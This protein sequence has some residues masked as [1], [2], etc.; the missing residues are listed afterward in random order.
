M[1]NH[2]KYK[3]MKEIFQ[4]I[5]IKEGY[6]LIKEGNVYSKVFIYE[7]KPLILV[8]HSSSQKESIILSYKEFLRQVNFDFQVYMMNRKYNFKEYTKN[9]LSHL[10]QMDP[11]YQNYVFD[12]QEKIRKEL[13]YET[14]FYM[15]VSIKENQNLTIENIIIQY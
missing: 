11:F 6:I 7:I 15:V 13:I 14:S 9:R 12:M 5:A 10:N 2:G 1:L 4:I 3:D 8:D